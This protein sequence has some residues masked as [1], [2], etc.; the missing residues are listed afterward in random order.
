MKCKKCY[1]KN[2]SGIDRIFS[3]HEYIK[4]VLSLIEKDELRG[5]IF[6]TDSM[7]IPQLKIPNE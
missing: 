1:S 6:N 7:K 5:A 4:T 3:L 2:W